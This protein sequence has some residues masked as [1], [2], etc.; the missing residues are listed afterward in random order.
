M[1]SSWYKEFQNNLAQ[2]GVRS[3]KNAAPSL[4]VGM[5]APTVDTS[6]W[7]KSPN[8]VGEHLLD[9]GGRFLDILS[10]PGYTVGGLL[11]TS[12]RNNL[13]QDPTN[14]ENPYEAAWRGFTGKDKEFF[15]PVSIMNP[16][17]EGEGFGET[18]TRF[19]GDFAASLLTDPTTYIG[20]GAVSKAGKVTGLSKIGDKIAEK[21]R[22]QNAPHMVDAAALRESDIATDT[23][24]LRNQLN[25]SDI[26]VAPEDS[27]I[28]QVLGAE[29]SNVGI[30]WLG[31]DKTVIENMPVLSVNDTTGLSG[32]SLIEALL[33]EPNLKQNVVGDLRSPLAR[34]GVPKV[35]KNLKYTTGKPADDLAMLTIL[36]TDIARKLREA[37]GRLYTKGEF[38]SPWEDKLVTDAVKRPEKREFPEIPQPTGAVTKG[39]KIPGTPVDVQANRDAVIRYT[40]EATPELPSAK[41]AQAA[42]KKS[43]DY[44]VYGT[45]VFFDGKKLGNEGLAT[46]KKH[47]DETTDYT[48][49][50]AIN[51]EITSIPLGAGKMTVGQYASALKQ[52]VEKPFLADSPVSV[53]NDVVG[54]N[55]YIKTR[56]ATY[57]E[58]AAERTGEDIV[59]PPTAE[60]LAQWEN[61]VAAQKGEKAAYEAAVAE[62]DSAV[63]Y[64][65]SVRP[66]TQSRREWINK[67][68]DKLTAKDTKRLNE[69]L[70]RGSQKQF[71]K[72]VDEIVDRES[73]L[74]IK[75]ID[76]YNK[77]VAD[78]RIDK[79]EAKALWAQFGAATPKT[80]EARIASIDKRIEKLREKLANDITTTAQYGADN[81]I[82]R[83][84][85]EAVAWADRNPIP[86][87]QTPRKFFETEF[88]I[89]REV[90]DT[91]EMRQF[92]EAVKDIVPAE[93]LG[94]LTPKNA[95][96][97]HSSIRTAL[98]DTFLH[99][100]KPLPK[101]TNR[102]RTNNDLETYNTFREFNEY[103]QYSLWKNLI[104]DIKKDMPEGLKGRKG[105]MSRSAYVY[106][107]AMPVL[108]AYDDI[109]RAYGIHPSVAP[110]KGLPLSLHDILSAVPRP[111]AEKFFFDKAAEI[112]PAQWLHIGEEAFYSKIDDV[113]D[114]SELMLKGSG[115]GLSFE[116][117][118]IH[119][120]KMAA[121]NTAK[122]QAAQGKIG[123]NYVREQ[124][125]RGAAVESKT[126]QKN[127][128][129]VITPEFVRKIKDLVFINSRRADIQAGEF[130][131][132]TSDAAIQK[133]VDDMARV[134]TQDELL[135]LVE[136][137]TKG[138]PS[139]VKT[140]ESMVPPPGAAVEVADQVTLATRS[141]PGTE[142]ALKELN[143]NKAAKLPDD[144]KTA[145][146]KQALA[147]EERLKNETIP[148]FDFSQNPELLL[149]GQA[150]HHMAPHTQES[151]LRHYML[152]GQN[153]A[154]DWS[155][156]FS[157][158][159]SKF[160]TEIGYDRAKQIFLDIQR[161]IA[162]PDSQKE[163]YD[164]FHRIISEVFD[165]T[166]S[167]SG[168]LARAGIDPV[169]LNSN[170]GKY[171]LDADKYGLRGNSWAEAYNSWRE[172]DELDDPLNILSR[173][174]AA[175]QKTRAEKEMFDRFSLDFGSDV[176]KPGYGRIVATHGRSRVAHL[177]DTRKY[178]PVEIID[179][180]RMLDKTM[181]EL[182][183]PSSNNALLRMYDEATHRLKS[184]LTIYRPGHHARNAYGDGWLNFM[185]GVYKPSTYK[186][187]WGV[188]ATRADHYDPEMLKQIDLES[189]VPNGRSVTSITVN[190]Q[191]VD[192]D[193]NMAYI[194]M[195]DSGNLP[196][197]AALED[198]GSAT[199]YG[200]AEA[201]D[202]GKV[203]W[204][205]P[206]GGRAHKVATT[207][208][209]VRDHYFRAA[210]FIKLME[211][212]KSLKV[213]RREGESAQ[214]AINRALSDEAIKWT[215]RVR[216]WHPDGTDLQAFE[217]NGLKRGILFYSWIRKMIPRVIEASVMQ[218]GRTLAFPKATY[219]FAESQGIDLNG[220]TDPF[221]TD[222]L[223]PEW[224]GGT[225]GPQFGSST[226]GYIGMRPGNPMMDIFDQYLSTPG[227]AFQTIIGATHPVVK[228]PYELAT[229][230][231]TQGVPIK[232]LG[233]YAVGQVPFG[234][235]VNT[236][237]GKP[238]GGV[239]ASDE[240]YD[241]GG[242]RDPKAMA[243]FNTLTGAGLID[244]SKPS[245]IK[246]GEFDLKY[247]R[248]EGP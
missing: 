110:G 31:V 95:Q 172:W 83:S 245:Y 134:R 52:G 26:R 247:G 43:H 228:I 103:K 91:S 142:I 202:A 8:G 151:M 86:V 89:K 175:V 114:I 191:K 69:A 206:T 131:Q 45:N 229:G 80:A 143:A 140:A 214:Q 65:E 227:Q 246:T 210:H 146:Q 1:T 5:I 46:L 63:P 155:K 186:K 101:L 98:Q 207:V 137:S 190:G 157:K 62:A 115:E 240:G 54:L 36:R 16:H 176:M 199:T 59:T 49:I 248:T 112:T 208:S 96:L 237:V 124:I 109:L 239:S 126:F 220:F 188:M 107:Q 108:K 123:D 161:G 13:D 182:A 88:K 148:E 158:N 147:V 183:K 18:A 139:F 71:E 90:F 128:D 66:D 44:A 179:N 41:A 225:Q 211:D 135:T 121:Q 117:S 120:G 222:Q 169:H 104:S 219:T 209:E 189:F 118:A 58:R 163:I 53:G 170:L 29:K 178:Y 244:M 204:K 97:L 60:E 20:A 40:W 106:D 136:N 21:A 67:H 236:L 38:D 223:F 73:A 100:R 130:V 3:R 226:Y 82:P 212:T 37:R 181:Q 201:I 197:Y 72:L 177:I 42:S 195:R 125:F 221:P 22:P 99:N 32:D 27:M 19:L 215:A 87:P 171:K 233:K 192:I 168:S 85:A 230:T 231:T 14:D 56:S 74:D 141:N 187:A 156:N 241:P 159:L 167:G 203:T 2:V 28:P 6:S 193:E 153:V 119:A 213:V 113:K 35:A 55:D 116:G 84:R 216:K 129:M 224:M 77:A 48:D 75:I 232:D 144:A 70:Y 11:N 145:G 102:M 15:Q 51:H 30:P 17:E 94:K 200:Q 4:N 235:L 111:V 33:K 162:P 218:P 132:T 92:V 64:F 185:D 160:E 174:Y 47:L 138:I 24:R 196:T 180:L 173:Y 150:I 105:D 198:L 25:N 78:G 205:T 10:R 81:S 194:L 57:K 61:A 79:S 243:L 9:W 152:S 165:S 217:R 23:D 76:D 149:I 234:S 122:R 12:M 242:I 133:F 127:L 7:S 39:E 68:R 164:R 93:V 34:E 184:G 50:S 154:M 238:V 166:D